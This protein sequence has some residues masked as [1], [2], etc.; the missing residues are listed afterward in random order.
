[1]AGQNFSVINN[2]NSLNAQKNL[3]ISNKGL[4]SSLAKISSGLRIN[5]AA[6]DAAGLS[7]GTA[8]NADFMSLTQAVRNANDGVGVIQVADGAL[9]QMSDMLARATQLAT[10]AASGTAGNTER[11]IINTEYQQILQ[12]IDRVA[13][14]SNYKGEKLFS[15][16]GAVTK[17]I[18]VGDTQIQSTVNISIGG[19]NGAGTAALGLNNTSLATA[20]GAQNSLSRIQSAIKDVSEMRGALGSQ[21]NRLLNSIGV[22]QVQSQNIL[23]AESSI[24]DANM[25]TEVSNLT[26][27]RILMEAGMASLAQ[28]NATNQMVLQLFK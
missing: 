27:N 7:I 3:G 13:N 10:Q 9:S 12:E 20:E 11:E 17:S 22:L 24:M 25:A 16:D 28:A 2:L 14:N 1:M 4:Y 8:L 23:A 18:F 21:Q 26:R 5:D 6:D 15:Q 19:A